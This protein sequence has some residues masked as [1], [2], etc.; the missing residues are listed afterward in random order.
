MNI[1]TNVFH[2]VSIVLLCFSGV[3][4]AQEQQIRGQVISRYNTVISAGINGTIAKLAAEEGEMLAKDAWIAE[5]QCSRINAA[6]EYAQAHSIGQKARVESTEKLYQLDSVGE[7]ELEVTRSEY[8]KAKA[9]LRAAEINRK[10]CRLKA[11]FD[12]VIAELFV[13]E[14][15]TVSIGEPLVRVYSPVSMDVHWM[16]PSQWVSRVKEGETSFSMHID[17]IDTVVT[18]LG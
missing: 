16:V 18:G 5:F 15:Q 8:E 2:I 13:N 17:D 7:L 4:Q 6:Y 11:P 9:E 14:Y 10:D 3:V 12:L 1:K